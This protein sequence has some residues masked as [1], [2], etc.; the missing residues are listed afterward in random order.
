MAN[1]RVVIVDDERDVLDSLLRG[2]ETLG[3]QAL[4]ATDPDEAYRLLESNQCDVLVVD[5][6]LG[7]TTGLD[8]VQR[9]KRLRPRTKVILIS[10]YIDHSK[11]GE[12]ELNRELQARVQ[13]DYYMAKPFS[14]EQLAVAINAAIDDLDNVQGDWQKIAKE[15]AT[16]SRLDTG[17]IRKLNEKIKSSLKSLGKRDG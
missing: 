12:E 7:A 6:L 11:L 9:V 14:N 15:Y 3:V 5:F 8:L 2:L 16:G 10:G 17:E 13:F 1:E 4:G